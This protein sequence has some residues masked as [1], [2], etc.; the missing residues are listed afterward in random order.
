[1]KVP[2][3]MISLEDAKKTLDD[4][5]I[6]EIE[7]PLYKPNVELADNCFGTMAA[8]F[9]HYGIG[10]GFGWGKNPRHKEFQSEKEDFEVLCG[11]Y[12][13]GIEEFLGR[14]RSK[15]GDSPLDKAAWNLLKNGHFLAVRPLFLNAH[16]FAHAHHK[17]K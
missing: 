8:A 12:T 3:N 6:R 5:G 17:I 15:W 1:M 9:A 7:N 14:P 13:S 10:T 2:I 4:A 11:E 16:R